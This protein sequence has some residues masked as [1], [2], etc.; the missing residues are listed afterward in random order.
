MCVLWYHYWLFNG[1]IWIDAEREVVADVVVVKVSIHAG[2]YDVEAIPRN[3]KYGIELKITAIRLFIG[4]QL[5]V[6]IS[7]GQV[8]LMFVQGHAF[9]QVASRERLGVAI[10]L[11]F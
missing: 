4:L 6:G 8:G 5:A 9:G 2:V 7:V 11:V 1:S 3:G 10:G